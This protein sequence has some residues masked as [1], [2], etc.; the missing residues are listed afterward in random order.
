MRIVM[1]AEVVTIA[2]AKGFAEQNKSIVN[3]CILTIDR[4]Y[5]IL[6]W[7]SRLT[8][9]FSAASEHKYTRER[10]SRSCQAQANFRISSNF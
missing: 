6:C 1:V 9:Y 10:G 3:M 5:Y 4:A 7:K 2:M 8:I